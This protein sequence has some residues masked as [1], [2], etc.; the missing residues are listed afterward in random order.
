MQL[1]Q[2]DCGKAP[3]TDWL[4]LRAVKAEGR[5]ARTFVVTE[6]SVAV[7]Y[8]CLSTGAISHS[9]GNAKLRQNMPDPI[10][11][12]V[13]G[14]LAIDARH[15]GQGLGQALLKDACK[16]FLAASKIVGASALVVHAIDTDAK[17]FYLKYGFR[18]LS[19]GSNTLYITAAT[20]AAALG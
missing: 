2:F 4:R 20:L 14:R 3:L 8:Y 18:E 6:N 13:L 5:S 19:V 10:P 16:R 17:A 11:I 1:D 15:Q 12:M 7:A 9:E